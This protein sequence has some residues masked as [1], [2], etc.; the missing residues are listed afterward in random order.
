VHPGV[1]L[2]MCFSFMHDGCLQSR[3]RKCILIKR[4]CSNMMIMGVFFLAAK[5]SLK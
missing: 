3:Y 1:A 5:Q 4:T 2:K